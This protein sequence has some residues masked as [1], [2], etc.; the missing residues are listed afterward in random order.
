MAK[1]GVRTIFKMVIYDNFVHADCHAGNLLVQPK[2][3][4]KKTQYE[5]FTDK[6]QT[7]MFDIINS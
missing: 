4:K 5:N 3:L 1:I 7:K 6:L 2:Q